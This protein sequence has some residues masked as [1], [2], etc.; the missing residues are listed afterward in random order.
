MN[1]RDDNLRY[2]RAGAGKYLLFLNCIPVS[3]EDEEGEVVDG[4]SYDEVIV[5]AADSNRDTLIS[6][7]IHTRY[8]VDREIALLRQKETKPAEFA[9]YDSFAELC[10]EKIDEMLKR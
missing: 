4:Y 2:V 10:K 6:S 8:N 5:E 3:W 7:L 1:Y 9:E